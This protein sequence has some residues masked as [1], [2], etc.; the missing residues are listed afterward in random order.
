MKAVNSKTDL[1]E[2]Q[3]R[4]EIQ[5]RIKKNLDDHTIKEQMIAIGYKEADITSAIID[6]QYNNGNKKVRAGLYMMA[7]GGLIIVI[8]LISFVNTG[9]FSRQILG[10]GVGLFIMGI[11][12]GN[13]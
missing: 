4:R 5:K 9:N 11:I 7:G 3:L 6:V 8:G 12:K 13:S 2:S 10:W 1:S